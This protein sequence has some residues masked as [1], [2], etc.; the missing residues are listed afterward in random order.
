[1]NKIL[2]SFEI[3]SSEVNFC[4]L[5]NNSNIVEF[6][7][8]ISSFCF[9][10]FSIIGISELFNEK[11]LI[12]ISKKHRIVF[13]NDKIKETIEQR[14]VLYIILIF[15]GIF[16]IYFHATMSAFSHFVDIISI[17]VLI[18]TSLYYITPSDK[19]NYKKIKYILLFIFH[20]MMCL[21]LPSIEI[22]LQFIVG[23]YIKQISDL[24]I[25]KI[26]KTLEIKNI[27]EYSVLTE[28]LK[29][30]YNNVKL[31][32]LGSLLCWFPDYFLC[33]YLCGYHTHFIFQI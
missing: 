23:F 14:I 19:T 32:F 1:M 2:P 3:G 26:C 16:S 17:S 12:N 27:K 18:I 4:E 8:T 25:K 10:I 31:I 22:F 6:Y 5:D 30:K 28:Y 13:D 7:N 20:L 29:N 15:I 9:I 24:K 21:F 11:E 33:K